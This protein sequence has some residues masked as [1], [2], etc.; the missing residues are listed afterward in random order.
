MQQQVRIKK[1]IPTDIKIRMMLVERQESVKQGMLIDVTLQGK[2]QRHHPEKLGQIFFQM[3]RTYYT[4][5]KLVLL[6]HGD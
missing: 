2:K 6:M 1:C 3:F 5:F 4:A